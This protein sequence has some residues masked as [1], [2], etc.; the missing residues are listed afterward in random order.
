MI[1]QLNSTLV[2]IIASKLF[3]IADK[4]NVVKNINVK[5]VKN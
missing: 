1:I 2:K 5:S 4:I 3:I